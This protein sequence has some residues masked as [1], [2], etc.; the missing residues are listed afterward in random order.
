MR[1]PTDAARDLRGIAKEAH[2][3]T[4]QDVLLLREAAIIIEELMRQLQ[5]LKARAET[6]GK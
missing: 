1:K 4:Y 6:E 2:W 5:E 3:L